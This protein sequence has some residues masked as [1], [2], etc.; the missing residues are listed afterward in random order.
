MVLIPPPI[1]DAFAKAVDSSLTMARK[2]L[3]FRMD[4]SPLRA[5]PAPYGVPAVEEL[6]LGRGI[7]QKPRLRVGL[8]LVWLPKQDVLSPVRSQLPAGSK[9]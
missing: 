1:I 3:L 9:P 8:L 6:R 5:E 2:S 4:K 7:A